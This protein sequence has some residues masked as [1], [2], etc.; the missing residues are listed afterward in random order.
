MTAFRI[1]STLPAPIGHVWERVTT[2]EGVN[3]ELRPL[4]RMTAPRGA[5]LAAAPVGTPWFRS[6]L[7]VLRVLPVDFDHLC[8]V[9]VDPPHG[10]HERSTMLS[11]SVWEHRRTLTEEQGRTTVVDELDYTP[12]FPF[13]PVLDRAVPVLFRHRHRRLRRR[14]G[15]A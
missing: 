3:D 12:R 2:L 1:A 4:M 15:A 7:L 5:T 14:F 13:G 11:A 10:F 8:L 6:W 9:R